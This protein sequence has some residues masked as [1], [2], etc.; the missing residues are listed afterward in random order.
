MPENANT[1][2]NA[3]E[4][5]VSTL[6]KRKSD[7]YVQGLFIALLAYTAAIVWFATCEM[8]ASASGLSAWA[9]VNGKHIPTWLVMS[10]PC[11]IGSYGGVREYRRW[12]EFKQDDADVIAEA[13]RDA[14]VITREFVILLFWLG[15]GLIAAIADGNCWIT[16]VPESIVYI[17][18]QTIIIL[19]GAHVSHSI[20][21]NKMLRGQKAS[22]LGKYAISYQSSPWMGEEDRRAGEGDVL[23]GSAIS[24][25]IPLEST[26][27]SPNS[28]N[29]TTPHK[30]VRVGEEHFAKL[31]EYM[32]KNECISNKECQTLIGINEFQANRMFDRLLDSDEIERTGIGRGAKYRLKQPKND[33]NDTLNA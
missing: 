11:L 23:S 1:G 28:G 18:S 8:L 15:Y 17:M 31:K 14:Q 22:G 24:Q 19:T 12:K 20:H 13:Q 25:P 4:E 9:F 10:Y 21:K 2:S 30:N 33:P 16:H 6:F 26:H 3:A 27:L 29:E 5:M 7:M 32:A